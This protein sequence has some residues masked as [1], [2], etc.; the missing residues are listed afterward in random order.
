MKV[1]IIA[2]AFAAGLTLSSCSDFL[3]EL[4]VT[5]VAKE[6]FYK[7]ESDFEQANVGIYQMLRTIYGVGAANYGSWMMGEMRSDNTTFQYNL[8]NRGYSDREYVAT[9]MDD[10]NGGAVGNK[11]N[12]TYYMIQRANQVIQFIEDANISKAAHDNYKGQA[13]FLRALG[14]FDLVQYFGDIPLVTVA[15]TTYE[16]AM[17]G[18]TPAADV[19]AQ[20]IADAQEAASLLPSKGAQK[21]GFANAGSAWMLLG[22]VFVVLGRWPEA[23]AALKNVTGFSLLDDYAAIFDPDNKN[24][25]ESI[26]E[27][28]Y[29]DDRTAACQSD[30]GYNFLP[31]LANPDVIEGYPS[32]TTNN[33]A[34]WNIPTPELIA[35]Y[36]AGDLRKDATIA[37]YTYP[38]DDSNYAGV[39][40]PYTRKFTHGAV[41]AGYCNED[42]PVYRYAE[43]LLLL[44]EACNEQSGRQADAL[45]YLNQ[46]HAH[47]RTGLAPLSTTSQSELRQ[48][49]QDERRIELA[50]EN[51]RWLDLVRTGKAVEVMSAFGTKVKANPEKYYYPHNVFP[52]SDS[53][54]VTRDRLLFPIPQ[55]EIRLQPDVM[56]QNPG[57]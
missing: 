54:N 41:Q 9:F 42:F 26:F 20:I 1:K 31:I 32:G 45:N 19:Y 57:Y 5:V 22:N 18:R 37:F 52:P 46:V 8:S 17:T 4:P 33:Y 14:Y 23:E 12:N 10:A 28:Q 38:A 11:Y 56:T 21:K 7:T 44:A 2:L 39:T 13:L 36:Q 29:W 49:I 34:G 48:L 16:Q 55:R 47:P 40:I 6:S 51:K 3:T 15:P 50:F 24:N 43:T 25:A 27:I 35:A 30:F 53:Y